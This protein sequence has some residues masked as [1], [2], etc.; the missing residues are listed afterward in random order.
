MDDKEGLSIHDLAVIKSVIDAACARGAIS[1]TEMRVVGET[2]ERLVAFRDAVVA[3]AN[4][5]Q[6][7]GES[8]E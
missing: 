6:T 5:D 8:N 2:Y 1:A 7:Q 4:T 3:Q